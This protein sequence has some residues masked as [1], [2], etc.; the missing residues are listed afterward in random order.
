MLK[1]KM[2]GISMFSSAGIAE[3]YLGDLGIDIVLANELVEDRARY[4]KHFY[5]MTEMV[6]G[7]IMS[8]DIYSS[9]IKKA[10]VLSPKFLLATPP[11]QGMSSLGK[12]EYDEDE[13]NYLIFAVLKV[14][15]ELDLDIIV[16]ENV[17]K[18]MKLFFPYK[19]A[20]MGIVDILKQKYS[21]KYTIEPV[22]V[23][24]KDYGVPQSRPRAIIKMYKHDYDWPMPE[25]EREITLR[26]AIGYLPSLKNGE[27]SSIPYHYA[28]K[29][30]DM[31]VEVMSHTPE[32]CSAMKNEVFFPK[33]K[34]GSKVS[35]FHNTY[36]RMHWDMPCA[37]VT[38]N[39]GMISGHNNVHPG[40]K[41]SDGT[42]SD[43][44]VL[45]LLELMIVS[46]LPTDWNLPVD[47]K[48]SVVRT[49]IGEAI[50]PRL[51]YKMLYPLKHRSEWAVKE[52]RVNMMDDNIDRANKKSK[53]TVMKYVNSF[54]LILQYAK[55][56]RNLKS[57]VD[58]ETIVRINSIMK[59]VGIYQPKYGKPSVDTTNFKICQ[60]VYFM[61]AYRN[62]KSIEKEIVFSPLGNL[63]IDHIDN[64]E[65]VAKIFA[66][67]LFGMPFSHPFNK[68][69]SSFDIYPFRLIFRL[70]LEPKLDCKLYQDELFYYLFWIKEA[71]ESGY[72]QLVNALLEL[73]KLPVEEKYRMFTERLSVQDALANALHE[74]TYLFGQ[75][76]SAGVVSVLE[77]T[78][79]G[80]LRQGGFGRENIP[81]F[82]TEA[83]LAKHKPT[84]I[85]SYRTDAIVLDVKLIPLMNAL[86]K[87]Y[88]FAEK[89]HDLL[90]TLDRQDYILHL[91]NFYPQE[92]LSELG[93]KKSQIETMLQITKGINE[94]SRNQNEGDCYRFENVLAD[95]F[96]EFDDVSANTIGRAGNTDVECIYLTINEKFAIEAKSTQ[97]KLSGINAG[98][99]QLH[100]DKIKAKY[101]IVVAP[102]YKPSV[103]ADIKGT[104]NV[105][106]TASSLSNF[107]YQSVINVASEKLSYEPLYEIIKSSLGTNITS[108]VNEYVAKNFGVRR[109]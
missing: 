31:H 66:T 55:L 52:N 58:E 18:F 6:V 17:P 61:F 97:T 28:L 74:T 57:R 83:E 41:L 10:K 54:D 8:E 63:L 105:M 16:I 71:D 12:K 77:G 78:Q 32:G 100:R 21:D 64:K 88:S 13:R 48:D 9:Y 62:E 60:I 82:I 98:R 14:I 106:I 42:Y 11:C 96:N 5:P 107:L 23:N 101:T 3:T 102:Y 87:S 25:K 39:S 73:R 76:Q 40:R 109:I 1:Q 43:P 36:N 20:Y 34:D 2:T 22:V 56:I 95:A 90:N 7:D 37:A 94:Y 80:T 72:E 15:D 35:G 65:W 84:G 86:L 53:W 69:D 45:S 49:I 75:L 108:K 104:C 67:M 46:S 4:Y 38:T 89:P 81:D 99:L 30:S 59:N 33:K 26:E 51:L 79:V 91:Y 103:E 85:R 70:L 68:M 24:A 27:Y 47:Y 29:H 44:R 93:I 50:P 19:G 92:L